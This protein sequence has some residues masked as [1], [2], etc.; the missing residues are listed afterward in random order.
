MA[1]R[2]SCAK[3]LPVTFAL[4]LLA[5]AVGKHDRLHIHDA[6][7][8]LIAQAA[9]RLCHHDQWST[10]RGFGAAGST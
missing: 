10:T 4:T 3:A 7:L 6:I 9:I 2:A 8:V 5:S 1:A